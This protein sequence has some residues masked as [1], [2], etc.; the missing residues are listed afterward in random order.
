[1]RTLIEC[2]GEGKVVRF[3]TM[4]FEQQKREPNLQG[5]NLPWFNPGSAQAFF[6]AK[7]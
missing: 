4:P 5:I 2:L 3:Q 6:H 1:M 7:I